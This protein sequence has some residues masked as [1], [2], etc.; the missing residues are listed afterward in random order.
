[1]FTSRFIGLDSAIS[2]MVSRSMLSPRLSM[3][4]NRLSPAS[5]FSSSPMDSGSTS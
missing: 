5:S 3:P 4:A 1:M 2:L